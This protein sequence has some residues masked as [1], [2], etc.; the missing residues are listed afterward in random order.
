MWE[1]NHKEGWTLKSWCFW[2]VVL[3]KTL[4]RGLLVCKEIRPVRPKG[5]QSWIFIGRTDAETEAPILWSVENW[6]IGKDSD[7]WKGWGQEDKGRQRKRW[8]DGITD[9]MGMSL[10]KLQEVAK[11]KEAWCSVYS[12]TN[13]WTWL[14]DW[15]TKLPPRWVKPNFSG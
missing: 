7:T 14:S 4:E 8:L 3:E 1:L 6:P 12:V 5:N 11:D 9:S 13:S 15:T 10:S 2:I